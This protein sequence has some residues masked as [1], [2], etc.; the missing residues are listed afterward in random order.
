M[1][2]LICIISRGL[3]SVQVVSTASY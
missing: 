2:A 3:I 1:K